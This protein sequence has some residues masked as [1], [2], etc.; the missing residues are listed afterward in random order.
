MA[1]TRVVAPSKA[2]IIA[3]PA[4]A[5][6][7]RWLG[8]ANAVFGK[9]SAVWRV[10]VFSSVN[11][12]CSAAL[13]TFHFVRQF[14]VGLCCAASCRYARSQSGYRERGAPNPSFKRTSLTGRRLTHT[15]CAREL[16]RIKASWFRKVRALNI[17]RKPEFASCQRRRSVRGSSASQLRHSEMF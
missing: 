2:R 7:L 9:V 11:R 10:T 13:L 4:S 16:L 14:L 6:F 1:S 12:C 8:L 3:V 15:L 5:F 17:H